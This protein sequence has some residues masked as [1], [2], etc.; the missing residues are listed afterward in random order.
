MLN[1]TEDVVLSNE[2]VFVLSNE[3]VFP[4]S[5]N[6]IYILKNKSVFVLLIYY[7]LLL[8]ILPV[9]GIKKIR[10]CVAEHLRSLSVCVCLNFQKC[11]ICS[12]CD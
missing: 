9:L 3:V 11:I 4:A 5:T 1:G 8:K 6:E 10:R 7:G 2:V 12:L